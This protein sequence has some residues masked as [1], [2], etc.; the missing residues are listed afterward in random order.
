MVFV[1]LHSPLVGPT[2]WA[3]V[4]QQLQQRGLEVVIPTLVRADAGA[5][6][7]WE[8]HVQAV[9]RAVAPVPPHQPLML[10]GHSGAGML[11]P[12]IRQVTRRP[13]A[14]YLFVDAGVPQD[15]KSRLDLFD[16]PDEADQF[17]EAAVGGFLLP[18][19]S[20]DVHE[21][22]PDA[23]LRH[24]FVAELA[25]LP[26]AVYEEPLPVFADWPDAP[27]GY[28]RFGANP[29]YDASAAHAQ[30][31]GWPYR[32]LQGA[33]FHML[34]DPVEVTTALLALLEQLGIDLAFAKKVV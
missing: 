33:H 8:Q 32:Q 11:L 5:V 23:T 15:G 27:C 3:L 14:A 6:P 17:R 4:G 29:A 31:A 9:A 24:R 16:Q 7:Y 20:E 21:V 22:I 18:W 13:V 28:L 30:Q 12:A 10:V 2:T 19:S 25:P 34:V 26:L 1:L